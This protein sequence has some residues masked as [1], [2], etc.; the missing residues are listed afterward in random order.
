MAVL[1]SGAFINTN[2]LEQAPFLLIEPDSVS[3][4]AADLK[5]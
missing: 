1:I 4:R 2:P 3:T 5:P